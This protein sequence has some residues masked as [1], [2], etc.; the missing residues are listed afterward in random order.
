MPAISA[1]HLGSIQTFFNPSPQHWFEVLPVKTTAPTQDIFAVYL[2]KQVPKFTSTL[3]GAPI[4]VHEIP[5]LLQVTGWHL[6]LADYIKTQASVKTLLSLVQPP[7][8]KEP[9]R[10]DRLRDIA[11]DYM[12]EIRTM[13]QK[14]AI[15]IRCLLMECPR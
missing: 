15:G 12:K 11:F 9:K 14:S 5:P 8:V 2:Q 3:I 4:R 6:H 1:F 7:F 13:A 10:L